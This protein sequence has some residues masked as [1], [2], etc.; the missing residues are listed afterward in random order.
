MKI[1]WH[2]KEIAEKR[3]NN[4]VA[5]SIDWCLSRNR[6]WGTPIPILV[7]K[8]DPDDIIFLKNKKHL[9]IL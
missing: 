1:N 5:N 7:N 3:F 2:P 4:W 9:E 8:K 6:I